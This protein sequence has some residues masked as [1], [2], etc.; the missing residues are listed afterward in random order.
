MEGILNEMSSHQTEFHTTDLALASFL[1]A[2]GNS[3]IDIRGMGSKGVF[4]FTESPKLRTDV[5]RW[6]NDELTPLRARSFLNGF[7]N[8]KGVIPLEY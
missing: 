4:V 5:V 3:L 2:V 7:R 1:L 6:T 8:L